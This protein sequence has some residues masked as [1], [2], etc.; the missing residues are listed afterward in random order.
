MTI[1]NLLTLETVYHPH[2]AYARPLQQAVGM[3]LI[4]LISSAGETTCDIANDGADQLDAIR[5]Y[6]YADKTGDIP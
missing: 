3:E 2:V 1:K 5:T 4:G 6:L